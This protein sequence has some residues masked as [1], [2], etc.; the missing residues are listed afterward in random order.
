[1]WNQ[2]LLQTT[3]HVL[4][5]ALGIDVPR[6]VD[7]LLSSER[8][9][10]SAIRDELGRFTRAIVGAEGLT[11][12]IAG[13][14][15]RRREPDEA[16]CARVFDDCAGFHAEAAEGAASLVGAEQGSLVREAVAWDALHLPSLSPGPRVARFRHD[17]LDYQARMG[18]SPQPLVRPTIV[19]A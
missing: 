8:P 6:Y 14:G 1:L 10:L 9:R 15:D 11:L 16:V 5:Y 17:W 12:P 4:H 13:W 3:L 7:A 18:S 2:R 19:R